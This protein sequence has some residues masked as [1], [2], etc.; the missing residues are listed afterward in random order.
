MSISP[1]ARFDIETL[2]AVAQ[3]RRI[4]LIGTP[5]INIADDYVS[6]QAVL[7]VEIHVDTLHAHDWQTPLSLK[8]PYDLAV[9]SSVLETLEKPQGWQL[10]ASLRDQ[11]SRQFCVHVVLDDLKATSQWSLTDFLSMALIRVNQY[12]AADSNSAL[13]KYSID[14]YKRTPDWL[15]P[16][17]WANPELWGKYWW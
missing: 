9:V 17:N 13:F 4:L 11:L 10:L 6:Q 5:L 12:Q 1:S 8:T 7:G 3:P 15:N 2:I 14:S 16:N